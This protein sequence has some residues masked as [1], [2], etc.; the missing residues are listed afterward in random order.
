MWAERE[1]WMWY[2]LI[3]AVLL[4]VLNPILI[5]WSPM[6]HYLVGAGIVLLALLAVLWVV[7]LILDASAPTDWHEWMSLIR[8]S[9]L[10]TVAGVL[11]VLLPMLALGYWL[12]FE[13]NMPLMVLALLGWLFGLLILGAPPTTIDPYPKQ[14]LTLPPD[15]PMRKEAKAVLKQYTWRY[16][17]GAGEREYTLTFSLA[18]SPNRVES[19]RQ[20]PRHAD[21]NRWFLYALQISPEVVQAS[22]QLRAISK[23]NEFSTYDEIASVVSFGQHLIDTDAPASA[24]PSTLRYPL[25]NLY[26]EATDPISATLLAG[27][28]LKLLGYEVAL[29]LYPNHVALGVG[30]ANIFDGVFVW[31]RASAKRYY[32]AELTAEGW[33]L[34]EVPEAYRQTEPTIVP[35]EGEFECEGC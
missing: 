26:D 14:A 4:A 27:S 18:I 3:G 12:V 30:G 10:K 31:N 34:G 11:V 1:F 23:R 25:E 22:E 20:R 29:L 21:R 35:L 13:P 2:L 32:Y 7:Y 9:G 24:S 33:H 15:E 17:R 5:D 19:F 16:Q 8:V 28:L 6:G